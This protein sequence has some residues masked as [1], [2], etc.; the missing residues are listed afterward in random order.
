[1]H[2]SVSRSVGQSISQLVGHS[3][4]KSVHTS[5]S[6]LFSSQDFSR[7]NL[8]VTFLGILLIMK[9]NNALVFKMHIYRI[10]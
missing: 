5:V 7:I 8:F 2:C 6:Q 9:M 4:G 3:V 10:F 1:M